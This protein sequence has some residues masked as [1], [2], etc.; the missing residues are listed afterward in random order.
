MIAV[1][2]R[3]ARRVA[4]QYGIFETLAATDRF[5]TFLAAVAAAGM[6]A[7]LAEGDLTI[8]VPSDRTF[9]ALTAERQVELFA[10][11]ARLR[12]LLR[13]HMV[14]GLYRERDLIP[15]TRLPN[16]AGGMIAL[17]ERDGDVL[18]NGIGIVTPDIVSLGGVVHELDGVLLD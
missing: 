7:E 4:S 18:A 8:F 14:Q 12:D 16:R 3:P 9:D 17:S 5:R 2:T 13:A 11:P 1:P 10:A 15:F 6:T